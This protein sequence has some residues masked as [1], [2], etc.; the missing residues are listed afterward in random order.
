MTT[1]DREWQFLSWITPLLVGTVLVVSLW[2]LAVTQRGMAEQAERAE[3]RTELLTE[4]ML[5]GRDEWRP[6]LD[7]INAKLDEM[8]ERTEEHDDG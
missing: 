5:D 1:R 4:M 3:D 7:E 2:L 8:L 6:Q